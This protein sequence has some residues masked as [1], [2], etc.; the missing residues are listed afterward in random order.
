LVGSPWDGG[1]TGGPLV[2]VDTVDVVAACAGSSAAG[3]AGSPP[4]GWAPSRSAASRFS[5]TVTT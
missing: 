4:E 3:A 5:I 2:A 1:L